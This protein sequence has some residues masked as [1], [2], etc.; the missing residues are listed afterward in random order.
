MRRLRHVILI[1]GL[2]LG[3]VA[4]PPA[5]AGCNDIPAPDVRWRRCQFAGRDLAGVDLSRAE[6]RDSSLLRADLSGARLT[7][8][9]LRRSKFVSASLQGLE[10]STRSG[11][12]LLIDFGSVDGLLRTLAVIGEP[13][14]STEQ[15]ECF[16]ATY[17][18]S[19]QPRFFAIGIGV[20]GPNGVLAHRNTNTTADGKGIDH[21]ESS[22]I[23][24]AFDGAVAVCGIEPAG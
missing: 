4:S 1:G 12:W 3:A 7:K 9:D 15:A 10:Q 2:L 24:P 14:P 21:L 6:I 11:N 22:G 19:G 23:L 5:W 20:A 17:A 8:A 18:A 16:V 13:T